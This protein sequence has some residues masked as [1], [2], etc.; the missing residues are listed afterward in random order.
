[1]L[2]GKVWIYWLLFVCLC[3]CVF[4]SLQI[5]PP[6]IKLVASNFAR[7]FI[8]VQGREISHFGEFR[9]PEAQNQMNRPVRK[10]SMFTVLVEYVR[11]SDVLFI[12]QWARG[13]SGAAEGNEKWGVKER[14]FMASA[15]ARAYNGSGGRAPSGVQGQSPW[16]GGQSPPEAEK[17]FAFR[18]PLE[19][20]NLPLFSLYCRLSKLLKFSIQHWQW[21]TDLGVTW[22]CVHDLTW[23]QNDLK[24]DKVPPHD[25]IWLEVFVT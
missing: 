6:A 25:S 21:G 20:T 2:I 4:V 23:H 1:M 13:P 17:L 10:Q 14:A 22:V 9:S 12:V 11:Q 7:R 5:S 8:G 3:V 15:G 18:R 19:V 16:S 24:V